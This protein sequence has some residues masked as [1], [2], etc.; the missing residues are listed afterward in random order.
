MLDTRHKGQ[1]ES[2]TSGGPGAQNIACVVKTGGEE[3]E[4]RYQKA[5]GKG[6][7]KVLDYLLAIWEDREAAFECGR[8]PGLF[9]V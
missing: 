5:K 9:K 2:L 1:I 8:G 4:S 7:L 3:C 6:A